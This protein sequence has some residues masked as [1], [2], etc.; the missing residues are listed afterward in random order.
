[1]IFNKKQFKELKKH[2]FTSKKSEISNTIVSVILMKSAKEITPSH[3]IYSRRYFDFLIYT[4]QPL[5]D[6]LT[7]ILNRIRQND[8]DQ[9]LLKYLPP[10]A[11]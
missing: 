7:V 9:E 2:V 8:L 11:I 5:I 4:L 6:E 1:M 10:S 3:K